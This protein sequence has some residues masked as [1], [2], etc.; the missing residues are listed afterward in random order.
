MTT[1]LLVRHGRTTANADG[2]LAGRATG[3]GLDSKGI[4]QAEELALRLKELPIT[5][6]ISSPLQ[7]TVETAQRI[8]RGRDIRI[9]R[10]KRLSECDYGDWTGK[11]LKQLAKD[12]LWPVIQTHPSAVTFPDGESMAAAQERAVSACRD[13]VAQAHRESADK[14]LVA[15][16]SHGDVIKSVLADALG[17]HLDMFQRIVVDPGSLS[18]LTYT[19]LRPFVERINDTGSPVLGLIPPAPSGRKPR[20]SRNRSDA[21]VGG[22]AGSR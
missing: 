6:L 10:D 14:A 12:P 4:E 11:P 16:V 1:L 18:V 13:W 9:V 17:M 19:P 22:G 21:A 7:R 5:H 2:I 20:R 8:A 15:V 3:I